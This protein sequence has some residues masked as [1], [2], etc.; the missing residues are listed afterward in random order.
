MNPGI[1]TKDITTLRSLVP[2]KSVVSN[3][4]QYLSNRSEVQLFLPNKE[5]SADYF[6]FYQFQNQ[7]PPAAL[8]KEYKWEREIENH[9]QV[10][11]REEN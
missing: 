7:L 9:I 4:P 8:P 1:S 11:R 5:Y 2:G 10:Y 3:L 6:V